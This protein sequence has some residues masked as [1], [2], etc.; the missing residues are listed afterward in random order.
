VKSAETIT[1]DRLDRQLLHAL[2]VHGRATFRQIATVL[3]SSE[4]TVARR[5][6]RLRDAGAVRVLLV[7]AAHDADHGQLLR[8]QTQPSATRTIATALSRRP[9]VSWIRLMA[10]GTEVLCGVR[11]RNRNDRD[12]LLLEQLPRTGRLLAVTA[13]SLLHHFRPPGRADWDGF[14]DPLTAVQ[15]AALTPPP[16]DAPPVP[17]DPADEALLRELAL[18]GR[19]SYTLLAQRTGRPAAALARRITALVDSGA[20]YPDIDLAPQLLDR[21]VSAMLYL[22]IAPNRLHEMGQQ[23]CEHEETSFVAA[24]TGPANLVASVHCRGVAALYSYV[25]TTL[26]GTNA[27]RRIETSYVFEHVKHARA[28]VHDDRL[29]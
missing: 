15:R 5:Y 16:A 10:A 12:E 24:C 21:P 9:D 8:L 26:G 27:V 28:L 29:G 7:P 14:D 4:Q 17:A 1:L 6:R 23:M 22:D 20:V 11:A 19:A 13:Y 2:A 3:D 18:D 25:S